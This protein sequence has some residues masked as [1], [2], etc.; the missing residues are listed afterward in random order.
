MHRSSFVVLLATIG[1]GARSG[2]PP[3]D[4]INVATA[5]N[6]TRAFAEVGQAFERQT[7][8]HVIYSFGATTQLAQQ[9]EHGAPYDVFAAAD[10]EHVD[11]L[12]REGLIRPETR[13]IYARGKLVLWVPDNRTPVECIE[14]LASAGVKRIALAN[15]RLAPYGR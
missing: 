7:G 14:D 15:P 8:I 12:A 10:A 4:Q 5:A 3:A 11:E 6:L 2:S 13:A 1:C 9:I